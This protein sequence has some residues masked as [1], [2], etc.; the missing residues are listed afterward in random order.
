MAIKKDTKDA[1]LLAQST[2]SGIKNIQA[3]SQGIE[4]LYD[5]D[6]NVVQVAGLKEALKNII[7]R[8]PVK[9]TKVKT[10]TKP[11][12]KVE[13]KP[14]VEEKPIVEQSTK[15]LEKSI[16]KD[17]KEAVDD[18][19]TMTSPKDELY[20]AGQGPKSDLEIKTESEAEQLVIA[21]EKAEGTVESG[22]KA[23][24]NFNTFNSEQ[25]VY[26]YLETIERRNAK[27]PDEKLKTRDFKTVVSEARTGLAAEL[28][29]KEEFYTQNQLFTDT[30]VVEVK[31][32][33]E[34]STLTVRDLATKIRAGANDTKTL[35]EFRQAAVKHAGIIHIFK[36]GRANVARSLNAFKIPNDYKGTI[37]DFEEAML[38]EL[39][40]SEASK[41]FANKLL[42]QNSPESFNK[43]IE[44]GKLQKT[45]NV[46][47]ELYINGLL[48]GIRTHVVNINGNAIFQS[49]AIP[50]LTISAIYNKVETGVRKGFN[51][52][53][54]SN[55][56]NEKEGV[57]FNEVYYRA[58]SYL[59]SYKAALNAAN[60]SFSRPNQVSGSKIELSGPSQDY[61]SSRYLNLN[62]DK[63]FGKGIDMAGKAIRFPGSA[64][65]WGDEF[66]KTVAREAEKSEMIARK[67]NELV[68]SGITDKNEIAEIIYDYIQ[69]PSQ[70]KTVE[71]AALYYSF[72]SELGSFGQNIQKLQNNF[73]VRI[74]LPFMK[75]PSNIF[76]AI[77]SRTPLSPAI[78]AAFDSV[79]R[80]KFKNDNVFRSKEMGKILF[81]TG[82]IALAANYYQ[83]GKFT[84]GA[85]ADKAQ[86][87]FLYSIGWQ[88]YSFVLRGEDTPEGEPNFDPYTNMPNGKHTY[89]NFGG[90]EPIAAFFAVTGQAVDI[91][92]RS[93]DPQV[94]GHVVTAAYIALTEYLETI[95]FLQSI[96]KINRLIFNNISSERGPNFDEV[97]EELTQMIFPFR[98]LVSGVEKITNPNKVETG[99][100]FSDA[101]QTDL[102][103][104]LKDKDGNVLY[105]NDGTPTYNRNFL[106]PKNEGFIKNSQD[107]FYNILEKMG[108]SSGELIPIVSGVLP[109]QRDYFGEPQEIGNGLGWG[110]RT[111]NFTSPYRISAG[112]DLKPYEAELFRLGMPGQSYSKKISGVRFDDKAWDLYNKYAF[113]ESYDPETGMNF[114]QAILNLYYSPEYNEKPDD[115]NLD[116]HR[117]TQ[118]EGIRKRYSELGI[119][120]LSMHED[121]N[122]NLPY[123]E[124][125]QAIQK[126]NELENEGMI[127]RSNITNF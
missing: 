77:L 7:K 32:M 96:A 93:N 65:I 78:Q 68:A 124:V 61:I 125:F 66:F 119:E 36:T 104:F 56:F 74:T 117:I 90:V 28:G 48:S 44:D 20:G 84:A 45:K 114:R 8:K 112:Q 64:L 97:Y 111:Y 94:R 55:Y 101:K 102:E 9:D 50:E 10:E 4:P 105:N 57:Q 34:A 73:V 70:I 71:D 16:V 49:M 106:G 52:V 92:N 42:E 19:L 69:Q 113:K 120:M 91:M 79:Y 18:P 26:K 33:L 89:I 75:T 95:P 5:A 88:P 43:M 15:T 126:R 99:V 30:Q 127:P 21:A 87:D 41:T 3:T 118:I 67:T 63:Y 108:K 115:K 86:R 109:V 2:A 62:P 80:Q 37:N 107:L 17:V 35:F 110:Y 59:G 82:L 98:S 85:P 11:E 40:G 24:F 13:E 72:Q 100:N 47:F 58:A 122:G 22:K 14:V 46:F 54:K 121:E 76:K 1:D 116:K 103:P 38:N 60:E 29:L 23:G 27:L 12:G 6:G 31:R 53:T 39:G 25:D 51:K 81:G 123:L 83:D